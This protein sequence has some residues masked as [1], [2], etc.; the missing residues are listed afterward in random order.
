MGLIAQN[1]EVGAGALSVQPFTVDTSRNSG[2][3]HPDFGK[4]SHHVGKQLGEGED[5]QEYISDEARRADDKAFFLKVRDVIRAILSEKVLERLVEQMQMA[6]GI[7][8]AQPEAAIRVIAAQG[9]FT[10]DERESVLAHFIKGG[11]L[12]MLGLASAVS[13]AAEESDDY[14]RTTELESFGGKL[15]TLNPSQW[16][17]IATSSNSKR[18]LATALAI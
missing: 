18:D 7:E 1:S 4:R 14:D 6:D 17:A 2:M 13:A 16:K 8:I 15:V 3:V 12:S 10:E 5:I 11:N 9:A